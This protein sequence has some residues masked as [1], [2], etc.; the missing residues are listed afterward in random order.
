MSIYGKALLIH[1][2]R[3]RDVSQTVSADKYTMTIHDVIVMSQTHMSIEGAIEEHRQSFANASFRT[4][5]D[6]KSRHIGP[7]RLLAVN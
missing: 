1:R 3:T 4:V 2:M 5:I 6:L 7:D